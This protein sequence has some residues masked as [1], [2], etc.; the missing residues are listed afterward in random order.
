MKKEDAKKEL[1]EN[2]KRRLTPPKPEGEKKKEIK[3]R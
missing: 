3:K 1:Q 2:K